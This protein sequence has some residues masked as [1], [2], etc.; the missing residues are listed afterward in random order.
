MPRL[1]FASRRALRTPW[2]PRVGL[3]LVLV[4]ALAWAPYQLYR[5]S[6]LSHY[7]RLCA[8]RDAL[9]AANLRL[10]RETEELRAELDALTDD[11]GGGGALS[12]AAIERAA[13]DQLGFVHSDEIVFQIS[14]AA[15][16][17]QSP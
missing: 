1:S 4:A 5:H 17:E 9:H 8:E 3:A 12:N 14:G 16:A 2:L 7:V 6:G 10:L 15:H 13:R 11:E